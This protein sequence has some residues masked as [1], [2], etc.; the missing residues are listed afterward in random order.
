MYSTA[1]YFT[2]VLET[3]ALTNLCVFLQSTDPFLIVYRN[4][5][6]ISPQRWWAGRQGKAKWSMVF[7]GVDMGGGGGEVVVAVEGVVVVLGFLSGLADA[8]VRDGTARE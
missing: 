8:V 2:I 5:L 4:S 7:G 3:Q 6:R 1:S